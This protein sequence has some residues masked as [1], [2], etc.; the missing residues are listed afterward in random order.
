MVNYFHI[1]LQ[2]NSIVFLVVFYEKLINNSLVT[3]YKILI[4]FHYIFIIHSVNI[5]DQSYSD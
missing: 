1:K 2:F 5:I 4:K 3:K